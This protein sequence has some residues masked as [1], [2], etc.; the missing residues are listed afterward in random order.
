MGHLR[1][2]LV[3]A[4]VGLAGTAC[5]GSSLVDI[6][7]PGTTGSSSGSGTA[8]GVDGATGSSSGGSTPP[9]SVPTA[10]ASTGDDADD[11]SDASALDATLDAATDAAM[12]ASP[13][14]DGAAVADATPP[15]DGPATS[16]PDGGA[17]F[18]CG[19][20]LRCDPASEYCYVAPSSVGP[21]GPVENIV[22]PLDAG[23]RYSCLALPACDA[24]DACVCIQG[25][26][27][28]VTPVTTLSANIVPTGPTC[29]CSDSK[30]DITRTC[31]NGGVVTL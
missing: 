21:V 19:P 11:P 25:G 18:A 26:G 3:M 20:S 29:S 8:V 27:G 10:D 22:F 12:D 15:D 7:A 30:G 1:S 17:S 5:S 13:S 28:I 24:S 14:D 23:S 16:S 31:T 6:D 4:S 9:M 2:L